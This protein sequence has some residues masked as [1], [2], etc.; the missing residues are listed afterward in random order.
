[1]LVFS[2]ALKLE[3]IED[4]LTLGGPGE[5]RDS[6]KVVYREDSTEE[7]PPPDGVFF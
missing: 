5:G 4:S 6:H 1:M 7:I 2:S 3:E